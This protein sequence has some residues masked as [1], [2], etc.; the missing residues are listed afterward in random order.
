MAILG[1]P[2]FPQKREHVL[3]LRHRETA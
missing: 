1:P 2:P 3:Q